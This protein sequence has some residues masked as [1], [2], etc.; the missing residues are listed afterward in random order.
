MGSASGARSGFSRRFD[1]RFGS[2]MR[3]ALQASPGNGR[4][5]NYRAWGW[6]RQGQRHQH[7]VERISFATAAQTLGCDLRAM[8]GYELKPRPAGFVPMKW[9]ARG[10]VVRANR[11]PM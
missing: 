7:P 3:I 5:H 11:P 4:G 6:C 2:I 9:A 10:S 8:N 1:E